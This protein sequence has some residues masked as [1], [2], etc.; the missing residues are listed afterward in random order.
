M[1]GWLAQARKLKA[2]SDTFPEDIA[3]LHCRFGQIHPFLDG[4]GSSPPSL[5]HLEWCR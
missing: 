4:K 5:A 3:M 2:R 1:A